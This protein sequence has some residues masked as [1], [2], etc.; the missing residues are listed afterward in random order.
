MSLA[1][2]TFVAAIRKL[3]HE[4]NCNGK[5]EVERNCDSDYCRCRCAK[6]TALAEPHR[7]GQV[8]RFVGDGEAARV[9]L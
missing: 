2:G 7:C 3:P 4:Y 5:Y 6:S 8:D 9:G 1:V